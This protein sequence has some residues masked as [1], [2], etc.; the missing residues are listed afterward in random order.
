MNTNRRDARRELLSSEGRSISTAEE[1]V[2]WLLSKD[3]SLR[4]ACSVA[5]YSPKSLYRSKKAEQAG[6][7]PHTLGRPRFLTEDEESRLITWARAFF[8]EEGED[9]SVEDILEEVLSPIHLKSSSS[10]NSTSHYLL[11]THKP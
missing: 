8:G 9:P 5:G 7:V 1:K 3:Y 6:R 2:K 4:C 11:L 10:K